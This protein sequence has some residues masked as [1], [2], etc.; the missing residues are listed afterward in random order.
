[1]FTILSTATLNVVRTDKACYAE[2]AKDGRI[3]LTMVFL[4]TVVNALNAILV[5]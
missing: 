4:C 3:T 5:A 2:L 1:M